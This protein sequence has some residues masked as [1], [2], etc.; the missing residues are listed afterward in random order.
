VLALATRLD[1]TRWR[2]QFKHAMKCNFLRNLPMQAI[3]QDH[4]VR[5]VIS[6]T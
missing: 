2:S 6:E 4:I 5:G 3:K 1:P